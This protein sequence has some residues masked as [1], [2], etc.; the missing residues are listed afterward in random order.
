M[1]V[2]VEMIV[3]ASS[4]KAARNKAIKAFH[5]KPEDYVVTNSEE[6]SSAFDFEPT[7]CEMI[8]GER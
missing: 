2:Q 7:E 4:K 6:V 1:P 8:K 3:S 5:G